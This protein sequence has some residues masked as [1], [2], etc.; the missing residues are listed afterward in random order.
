MNKAEVYAKH[1]KARISPKKVAIVMDVVRNKKLNDAKIAL[2][3]DQS[4]SAK[5]LL[6]VVKSAEANAVNNLGLKSSD[7]RITDIHVSGARTQKWGRPGSKGRFSP[8]LKRSSH[9][10]VGLSSD[11]SDKNTKE[12]K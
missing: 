5:M 2:A 6:K 3:F 1:N 4:K 10:V 9:I 7:L 11:K 8:I 12:K